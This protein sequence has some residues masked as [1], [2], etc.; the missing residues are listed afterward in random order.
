MQPSQRLEEVRICEI[1]VIFL[2]LNRR[3]LNK[4]SFQPFGLLSALCIVYLHYALP[5]LLSSL[6]LKRGVEYLLTLKEQLLLA[7]QRRLL[8]R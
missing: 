5:N 3:S 1:K 7:S 4:K 2:W 8:K 6:P